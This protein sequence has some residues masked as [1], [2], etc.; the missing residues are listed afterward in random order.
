MV[1]FPF[2]KVHCLLVFRLMAS[3][4]TVGDLPCISKWLTCSSKI[5]LRKPFAVQN[6]G[7][8]FQCANHPTN[9][10]E[11]EEDIEGG[12]NFG[13]FHPTERAHVESLSDF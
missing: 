1:S 8:E 11:K 4:L 7:V 6:H 5:P 13:G 3:A 12:Y 10:L 2:L 9:L